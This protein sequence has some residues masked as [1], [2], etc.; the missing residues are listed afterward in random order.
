MVHRA[1]RREDLGAGFACQASNTNRTPPV[2]SE[3]KVVL[4]CELN[5]RTWKK[6]CCASAFFPSSCLWSEKTLSNWQTFLLLFWGGAQI[7]LVVFFFSLSVCVQ[8]F[9]KLISAVKKIYFTFIFFFNFC[10]SCWRF[11]WHISFCTAIPQ[12]LKV[13]KNLTPIDPHWN[14]L[15]QGPNGSQYDR[16]EKRQKLFEKQHLGCLQSFC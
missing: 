10:F 12:R 3:V 11:Y 8:N 6:R 1:L 13:G 2:A 9:Q 16:E 14:R 7:E 15:P 4:N 5:R